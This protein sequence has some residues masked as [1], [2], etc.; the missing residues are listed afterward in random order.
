MKNIGGLMS[1][2]GWMEHVCSFFCVSKKRT[3]KKTARKETALSSHRFSIKLLYYC[4][5]GHWGF[6]VVETLVSG[7]HAD[8][9]SISILIC[10]FVFFLLTPTFLFF[11]YLRLTTFLTVMKVRCSLM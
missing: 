7:C 1:L 3:K 4:G 9:G 6:D 11:T 5:E 8:E 2:T 10:Y